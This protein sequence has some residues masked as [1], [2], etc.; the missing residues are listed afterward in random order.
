LTIEIITTVKT[1]DNKS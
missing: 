1:N